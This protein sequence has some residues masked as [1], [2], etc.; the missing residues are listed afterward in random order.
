MMD[1]AV[2]IR[3]SLSRKTHL[4]VV[5]FG[6][7][8]DVW[9]ATFALKS[10]VSVWCH[11]GATFSCFL[12]CGAK[13]RLFWHRFFSTSFPWVLTPPLQAANL[14]GQLSINEFAVLPEPFPARTLTRRMA[15]KA[16]ISL[17]HGHSIFKLHRESPLISLPHKMG[18]KTNHFFKKLLIKQL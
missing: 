9:E 17:S 8:G 18:V 12:P 5:P 4:G 2:A 16:C 3:C 1:C 10:A 11:S 7:R 13:I 6:L 15:G 14:W